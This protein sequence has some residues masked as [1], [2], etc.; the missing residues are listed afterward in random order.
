[1]VS[2]T[3]HSQGT[4]EKLAPVPETRDASR[5]FKPVRTIVL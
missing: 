2:R 5:L 4:V 3:A 1:M